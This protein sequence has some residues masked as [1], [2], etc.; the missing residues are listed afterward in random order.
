M[1]RFDR[2][3]RRAERGL[4]APEPRRSRILMEMA[5]DLEDLYRTYRE[6]G[7]GET[8]ARRRAEEW[9]APSTTALASL[10][11]VHLPA[12]ERLLDRLGGSTR[13]RV[14]LGLVTLVSLLSVGAGVAGALR[15][16]AL[17]ASS[18]G[19]WIL[20]A[21]LTA[22]LVAGVSQGYSLFV[23]G[24]RLGPGWSGR[25]LPVLAAAAATAL[26]GLLAGAVRLSLT[27]ASPET[28]RTMTDVWSQV[29]TA[30]GVAALG[31]TGALFLALLWLL[32][33][34]RSEVVSRA[35]TELRETVGP[36]GSGN[37]ERREGEITKTGSPG[38]ASA[39]T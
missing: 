5:A 14:E 22:G 27:V 34:V 32:L 8:E 36:L 10:R 18:P 17:S 33:R 15:S 30:T 11:S 28:G 25:L 13:G 19:L 6:Q 16:G 23:R 7:L 21:F 4:Q 3:L 20:A 29:A 9:L 2:V 39:K 26:T 24:D 38:R 37:T 1:S 31:L 12:F 35:R